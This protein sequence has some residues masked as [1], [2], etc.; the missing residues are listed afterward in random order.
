MAINSDNS[1]HNVSA[2][3]HYDVLHVQ[4]NAPLPIIKNAYRALMQSMKLHPD[5]GGDSDKAARINLAYSTL[6]D[7]AKRDAYDQYLNQ[8]SSAKNDEHTE[9]TAK[10]DSGASTNEFSSGDQAEQTKRA[11][12]SEYAQNKGTRCAFCYRFQA[13]PARAL[14]DCVGCGAPLDPILKGLESEN[15]ARTIAR[16]TKNTTIHVQESVQKKVVKGHLEDMSPHGV[17]F[18][19]NAKLAQQQV[20]KISCSDFN[21]LATIVHKRERGSTPTFYGAQFISLRFHHQAGNFISTSL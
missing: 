20:V 3:T 17:G 16:I 2:E 19:S 12:H 4:R 8:H 15:T 10:P 11:Q 9:K 14:M 1:A 5:L 6:K 7:Q 21:G 18:T 13:A